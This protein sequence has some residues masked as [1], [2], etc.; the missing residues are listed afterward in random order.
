VA[1]AHE[2]Q[3]TVVAEGLE[4]PDQV[5]FLKGLNCDSAQGYLFGKPAPADQAEQF[6]KFPELIAKAA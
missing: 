5:A 1:L 4:T 2:L 6:L 3:I